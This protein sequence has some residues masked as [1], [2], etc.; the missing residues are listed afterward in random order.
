MSNLQFSE[1]EERSSESNSDI[2]SD[3]DPQLPNKDTIFNVN[4]AIIS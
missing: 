3:Y 1:N 4:S 2:E